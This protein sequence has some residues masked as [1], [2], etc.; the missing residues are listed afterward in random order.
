[1]ENG[2]ALQNQMYRGARDLEMEQQKMLIHPNIQRAIFDELRIE[3]PPCLP[4][5]GPG[6]KQRFLVLARY[7]GN[8]PEI[9][10]IVAGCK[11]G[12]DVLKMAVVHLNATYGEVWAYAAGA[13]TY[14]S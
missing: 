8:G 9:V 13:R 6:G 14:H 11:L 4:I 3:E 1:M 12:N 2:V 7:F 5:L 10:G